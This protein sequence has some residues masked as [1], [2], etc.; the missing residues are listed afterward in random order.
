MP[1]PPTAK[2]VPSR[3]LTIC[4]G[5][6][7]KS[8][9]LY[10]SSSRAT[11]A[12]LEAIYDGPI[13]V[14]GYT[15]QAVTLE[16]LPSLKDGDAVI[17][18]VNVKA[19]SAVVSE[20]GFVVPLSNGTIVRAAGCT[21]ASCAKAW[22]GKSALQMDQLQVTFKLK[23]VVN[24]SDGSAVKASDSVYSFQ[25]AS[26]PTTSGSKKIND[27]TASYTATNDTTVQW[28]SKPG[29]LPL[30]Y[31]N[32]FWSPLPEHALTSLK[33][34]DLATSELSNRKPMGWGPYVVQDWV[35]GDHITLQ[36]NPG[37]F[38]AAEGLPKFDILT[39]RFLGEA[40]GGNLEALL[41]GECDIVDQTT[42]LDQQLETVFD[43]NK[44]GKLKAY[45][46]QGPEEE[47]LHFGIKPAA[48][49]NGYSYQSD[50]PDFF[51]DVKVRQ[52]VTM[53][54]NRQKIVDDLLYG[55]STVP[56]SYISPEHPQVLAS[57]KALPYDPPKGIKL[58][59]EVGWKDLD[60]NPATP[61][62]SMG[63]KNITGGT[64]FSISLITSQSALRVA[65]A[66]RIAADLGAC[67]IQ[68]EVKSMDQAALYAAGPDG[69]LFGRTFDLALFAWDAALQPP[70]FLF[71]T[72]QIPTAENKWLAANV[73]GY[74]NPI[75]DAACHAANLSVPGSDAAL[76]GSQDVQ[77]IL[78]E[79][80]PAIPL[81]LRFKLA[82]SRPDLCGMQL[83][84]SA[85]SD[86]WNLESLDY[87]ANCPK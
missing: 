17:K 13:D 32:L 12:V 85:R 4:L 61:L 73:T 30:H 53:C 27:R 34:A 79:E 51:G 78:A 87:G 9:Y 84:A 45:V 23:A 67:G 60:N 26:D 62:E 77:Q 18:Q 14:R 69:P 63:I 66:K 38:R 20:E 15:P 19:G 44:A 33:P 48:Y 31:E 11:W 36:K 83:D 16:K 10:G 8:L 29:Y 75:Y 7:P 86:L 71:E 59:D 68:V 21:D 50:R 47:M 70:C 42:L 55:F 57:L 1:I 58:L 46:G 52:A 5:S 35:A 28:L 22:D 3:A 81:F 56:A 41:N 82:A 65:I 40:A 24:W 43:L 64:Q 49:D 2:P 37:Y 74:S 25:V 6:E 39:Y 54:I 80:L 76:K 72:E